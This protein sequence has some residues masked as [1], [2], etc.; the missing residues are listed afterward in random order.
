[1]NR[2]STAPYDIGLFSFGESNSVAYWGDESSNLVT[3]IYFH[4][5]GELSNS[6]GDSPAVSAARKIA[7]RDQDRLVSSLGKWSTEGAWVTVELKDPFKFGDPR[8][9]KIETQVNA[10]S[11]KLQDVID[12]EWEV[13]VN[14]RKA[15]EK[16]QERL[17]EEA[18]KSSVRDFERL[19]VGHQIIV[20]HVIQM[21]G[22]PL[23]RE[24]M[25]GWFIGVTGRSVAV[26]A[27]VR[28]SS[29]PRLYPRMLHPGA[30]AIGDPSV[31][32]T[33]SVKKK[34]KDLRVQFEKE[35]GKT[36]SV[37]MRVAGRIHMVWDEEHGM[38]QSSV[39]AFSKR[40]EIAARVASRS[41]TKTETGGTSIVMQHDGKHAVLSFH[42]DA[43]RHDVFRYAVSKFAGFVN[44]EPV[45]HNADAV[46][47][48]V[49]GSRAT[50]AFD[51]VCHQIKSSNSNKES[52]GKRFSSVSAVKIR[53][54]NGIRLVR[55][56]T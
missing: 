52:R 20:P 14:E 8:G 12:E 18:R 25:V 51:G 6:K 53:R 47:F 39:V 2:L 7:K 9:R 16:E 36:S 30:V 41:A 1:M 38:S 50:Q 33:G 26:L 42:G 44:E 24:S 10:F 55:I 48:P 56:E 27:P 17:E 28:P 32:P 4:G 31:K 46:A 40:L 45:I 5:V 19:P 29:K 49:D 43:A 34:I 35:H 11:Q 22:F 21:G 13:E 3:H 23:G 54:A 37:A 15:R